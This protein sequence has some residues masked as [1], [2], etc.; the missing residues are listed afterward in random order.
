M[1]HLKN[2]E[3]MSRS[4]RIM[5]KF[6]PSYVEM[7]QLEEKLNVIKEGVHHELKNDERK[8]IVLGDMV[9]R[10]V[11]KN[12]YKTD[13]EAMNEYLYNLGVLPYTNVINTSLCTESEL[14]LLQ[15]FQLPQPCTVVPKF[16][17]QF[18]VSSSNYIASGSIETLVQKYKEFKDRHNLLKEEY[19][20]QKKQI[21]KCK[22][23]RSKHKVSYELGSISRVKKQS[24]YD[25][26]SLY[27]WGVEDILLKCSRP[28]TKLLQHYILKG[29]VKEKEL[30]QFKERID[31]NLS[32]M[33]MSLEAEEKM[34]K[35]YQKRTATI[36][37][38]I[39]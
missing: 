38:N 35:H 19:N 9:C 14:N 23:L 6:Y 11:A 22:V 17:K 26:C 15:I 18:L 27:Q 30:R 3:T 36:S 39:V 29:I 34:F 37:R 4:S 31:I 13:Y 16:N 32:F 28:N 12:T 20:Q 8:R 2:D 7:K 5:K 33:I 1:I 25:L 21:E 10:F 24:L